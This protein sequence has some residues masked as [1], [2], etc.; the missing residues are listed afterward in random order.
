MR[1]RSSEAGA[2]LVVV[3]AITAIFGLLLAALASQAQV[4]VM[5]NAGVR[6]ERIDQYAAAGAIDSAISYLRGDRTFGRQGVA[7]PPV[8]LDSADGLVSV[9]CTPQA[10]SG[11]VLQTANSPGYALLTTAG[12]GGG[13]PS[14]VGV[15]GDKNNALMV[16]GP[17]FSN[18]TID[19]TALDARPNSVAAFG[20]CS[21]TVLAIPLECNTGTHVNDPG[22]A[23]GVDPAS[24][25]VWASPIATV[26]ATAP[27]P[28]CNSGNKVATMA[29][30]S[31]FDL[32]AM[33]TAFGS[34]T[35][36]WMQPG[37]YYFD[38]GVANPA[39]TKWSIDDTV[40]GGTPLGWNPAGGSTPSITVPGACDTTLP[41]VH[42]VFAT[43]SRIDVGGTSEIELC[44]PVSAT[45][46]RVSLYG[47][48]SSVPG[49]LQ[50][51][52]AYL[53]TGAGASN[54]AGITTPFTPVSTING[55][56][57]TVT[58]TGRRAAAT[59]VLTGYGLS[60]IPAGSTLNSVQVKVAH[61]DAN[62]MTDRVTVQ[63][64]STKLCDDLPVPSHANM[65]TDTVA[66]PANQ[67]WLNPA[68]AQVTLTSTR[69]NSNGSTNV[70]LDGI[71]LVV[72]YTPPGLRAQTVGTVLVN[73]DAGGGNKGQIYVQGT[74]Y[75]PY[76][77]FHLDFK[78]N[79]EA[80]FNRGVVI[81]SFDATNV[82]PSQI[83]APLSLPG[84][85]NYA[86]RV[87]ELVATRSGTRVLRARVTFD[88]S[89]ATT[90]G[91]K[92]TVDAW[93]AV[94]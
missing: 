3:L 58:V 16:S 83:F 14:G 72:T 43:S 10:G 45:T 24:P 34:C 7:C 25:N 38:W 61:S 78:N 21:G 85:N 68:D 12:L 18:S 54:P 88:D 47:R 4:G 1:R 74:V 69:P 86:N 8:T 17:V 22:G 62:N 91:Q 75:A 82:P 9:T 73:M 32:N 49:S 55:V 39:N 36:I 11:A 41:G 33:T 52:A 57:N 27:A 89:S 35:V 26:P 84:P 2:S 80:A 23:F 44:S 51:P 90:P 40:I 56:S 46:Q 37:S 20:A 30:G 29:P 63:A 59:A 50:S 53:P 94:N 64:G 77:S 71:E 66:C 13:Y 70:A 15:S 5:S 48:K 6:E 79:N 31:Y 65:V 19:V 76:A 42:V 92:A 81:G 28:T 60:A 67:T 93:T 87:V